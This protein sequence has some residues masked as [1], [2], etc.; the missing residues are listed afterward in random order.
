MTRTKRLDDCLSFRDDHLFI[1]ERDAVSI[2]KEFGSP[3][4]VISEN[5]LRR[6]TRR[7]QTAFQRGWPDGPVKVMPAAKANWISG[8][9]RILADEGCGCDVYSS[10]ELS[11]ALGA[12][13]DPNFISVNGVPKD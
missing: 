11:A 1:E 8:V 13:F 2:V 12:G 7:F 6:N 9:Q 3:V 4:F 10:G 5:Q